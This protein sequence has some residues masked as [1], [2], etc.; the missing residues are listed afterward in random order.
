MPD[1]FTEAMKQF[2]TSISAVVDT[3]E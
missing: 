1:T 2:L 3:A